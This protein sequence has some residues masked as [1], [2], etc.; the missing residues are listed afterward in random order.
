MSIIDRNCVF[1]EGAIRAETRGQV[2]AVTSLAL[3]GRMEPMPLRVSVTE[4]FDPAEVKSLQFTLEESACAD[5]ADAD[6]T[7]VPGA[8]W[9]V[10]GEALGLGARLGP[11]FLPQGTRRHFLRLA[12][13]PELADGAAISRGR[14]FAALT[15]EDD[16]PWEADLQKK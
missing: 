1:F 10:P 16:Q 15:R 11:R 5:A 3:P 13:R 14:I 2:V 12:I 4:S 8:V 6:W 9:S 7:Q